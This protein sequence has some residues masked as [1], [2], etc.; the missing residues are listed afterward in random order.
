MR[1]RHL[2]GILALAFHGGIASAQD[3]FV[4]QSFSFTLKPAPR[5]SPLIQARATGPHYDW[6]VAIRQ[7]P[8]DEPDHVLALRL[9]RESRRFIGAQAGIVLDMDA[10]SYDHRPRSRMR[11]LSVE[12]RFALSDQV[13]MTLGFR[14]LKVSNRNANVTIGRGDD[15][16]SGRDWFLPHAVVSYV[17]P[18][19]SCWRW[20][21]AKSCGPMATPALPGRSAFRAPIS[22]LC[23]SPFAPKEAGSRRSAVSGQATT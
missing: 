12:D 1:S 11:M 10:P 20:T 22:M 18:L 15:R 7:L 3:V 13:A 9:Q 5:R 14:G 2:L 4:E 19:R 6:I 17:R 23:A 16:L 21:I 8:G